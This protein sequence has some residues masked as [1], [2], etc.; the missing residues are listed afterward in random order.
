MG[1]IEKTSESIGIIGGSDGP[2]SVIFIGGKQKK[3]I[4]QKIQ[5]YFHEQKKK[6][7]KRRIKP[8]AHTMEEVVQLICD[9]YGFTELPKESEEYIERYHEMRLSSMIQHAPEL[10]GEL[11]EIPEIKSRDEEEFRE[12]QKQWEL[13]KQREREISEEA[14]DIDLHLL[15]KKENEWQMHFEIETQFGHISGGFSGPGRGGSRKFE[16]FFKEVYLYYGV[17]EEDIAENTRRYKELVRVL[18]M[19]H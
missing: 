11:A 13:R 17:T 10:L 7:A 15:K 4:K 16:K 12:Y 14:F 8:G 5:K 3:T 19:R 6:R 1:K 9:T 2:T 18:A